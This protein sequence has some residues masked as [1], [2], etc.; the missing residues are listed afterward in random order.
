MPI[1]T[2]LLLITAALI[3]FGAAQRLLDRMRLTD[4]QA[5]IFI[6]LM[7]AGSFIT[8]PLMRGP[9]SISLNLGGAV[10]PLALAIYLVTTADSAKERIRAIVSSFVT[11]GIVFGVSQLTDFDPSSPMRLIDP[12]G[13][14]SII[15]GIV[16]YLAGRSR[17]AAFIAGVLG[18]F[19][20]DLIHLIRAVAMATPTRIVLG[21][22]GVFDGMVVA[23][24][25]A[26]GL[27]EFVGEVR[28][29]IEGGQSEL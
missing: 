15:A 1:G 6:A 27:A 3:Y 9:T 12:R 14:F 20:V 18:L 29:R 23:G 8:V 4:S 16:G 2:T 10:V 13:V 7:I 24:L 5:L 22:A 28:E 26:I 19:I 11:A 17:R 25:I 21:G